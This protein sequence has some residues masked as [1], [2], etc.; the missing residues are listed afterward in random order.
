MSEPNGNV[1]SAVLE[2]LKRLQSDQA[3]FRRSIEDRLDRL[4]EIARKQRRDAAGVLVMMRATATDFD[5]RVSDVEERV[6]A[7]ESRRS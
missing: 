6:L 5:E 4:E 7:L 1:Q 2:I 3:D